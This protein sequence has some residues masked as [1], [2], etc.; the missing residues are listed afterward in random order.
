MILVSLVVFAITLL[1]AAYAWVTLPPGSQ[2]PNHWNAAGEVDGYS[3]KTMGLLLIP[4][5][6]LGLTGLFA[7]VPRVDPK[8]DNIRRSWDAYRVTWIGLLGVML[9]VQLAIVLTALGVPFKVGRL[10]PA[11]VGVLFILMGYY[12]GRIKPNYM[13]GVRTPWTLTSELSWTKTHRLTGWLFAALGL[14]LVGGSLL[15]PGEW[16]F[17]LLMGGMF[18]ML[19]VVAAYSYIVW[20]DDPGRVN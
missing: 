14:V 6:T 3:G 7:L 8:G 16:W 12:M 4:L 2:I 20:R 18:T 10:I 5:I 13:F 15:E 1:L 19:V 9:F 11:G 17:W